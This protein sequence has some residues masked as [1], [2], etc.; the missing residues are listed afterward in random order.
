MKV[1]TGCISDTTKLINALVEPKEALNLWKQCGGEDIANLI[2]EQSQE[3]FKNKASKVQYMIRE[4][5]IAVV[6]NAGDLIDAIVN[7]KS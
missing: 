4:I 2:Y 7:G 6:P 3:N 1:I 5:V